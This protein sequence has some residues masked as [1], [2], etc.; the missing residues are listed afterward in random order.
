MPRKALPLKQALPP[1][2]LLHILVVTLVM[3]F[4]T[5]YSWGRMAKGKYPSPS[6]DGITVAKEKKILTN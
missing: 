3:H 1:C 4:P 6:N 5:S 2:R